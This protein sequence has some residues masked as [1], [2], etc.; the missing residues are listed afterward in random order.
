MP[1]D[2][3]RRS[4]RR[5][6]RSAALFASIL[7]SAGLVMA[8]TGGF[9]V[10]KGWQTFSWPTTQATILSSRLAVE[11]E[12]RTVPMTDKHRGG[13]E[14][15]V[16]TV[17]LAVRYSYAVDGVS[18]EGGNLEPWD[19]GIQSVGKAKDLAASASEGGNV[20][21]AYDP[22]DPRRSYLL[23]GPSTTAL[24][25]AI[26]GLVLAAVGF[27]IGRIQRRA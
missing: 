23:P 17:N 2:Q 22:R 3:R 14:Q 16:E 11:T 25:L 7:M 24:T 5:F 6:S 20:P 27:T 8:L 13:A 9:G 21:V 1:P 12:T 4:A 10:W 19:F 18:F 15:K 26:V